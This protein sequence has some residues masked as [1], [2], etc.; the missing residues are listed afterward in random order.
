MKKGN[1]IYENPVAYYVLQLQLVTNKNPVM[2]WE[3]FL[4]TFQLTQHV[5]SSQKQCGYVSLWT[6]ILRLI[7]VLTYLI[8]LCSLQYKKDSKVIAGF[9]LASIY[10]LQYLICHQIF[11]NNVA[12]SSS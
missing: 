8:D 11:I 7:E 2:K 4:N 9:L 5:N 6:A 12:G 10:K 3:S 1:N